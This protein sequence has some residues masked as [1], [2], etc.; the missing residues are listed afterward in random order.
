M[1]PKRVFRTSRRWLWAPLVVLL[2]LPQGAMAQTSAD[3]RIEK[4]EEAVRV[5]ERKVADLESELRER[6]KAP[7]VPADK[8]AWRKLQKGMSESAVEELLGSPS[9]IDVFGSFTI[10]HYGDPVGGEVQ[11]D[12]RSRTVN[13]WH[14]P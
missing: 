13:S 9:K 1:V 12:G 3:S 11:F 5:L 4:L 14:E 2:V 10:W 7:A 8:A 6:K